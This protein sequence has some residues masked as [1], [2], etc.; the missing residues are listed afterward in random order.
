MSSLGCKL[1]LAMDIPEL[2]VIWVETHRFGNSTLG[3]ES[4]S[5]GSSPHFVTRFCLS[6]I[7]WAVFN[8]VFQR[9]H[10][11]MLRL[12]PRPS[13]WEWMFQTYVLR[14]N[15]AVV[16]HNLVKRYGPVMH[17]RAWSQDLIILSSVAAVEEFYKLHDMEFGARPSSMGRP[18]LSNALSSL[19]FPPLAT[20]WKHIH[21]VLDMTTS[22]P[23]EDMSSRG[24]EWALEAIHR[25]PEV[26]QHLCEELER[27]LEPHKPVQE[28]AIAKLP[29]LQAVVKELFRLHTPCAVS[30]PHLQSSDEYCRLLGFEVPPRT[31]VLVNMYSVQRDPVMWV[32]PDDFDPVRFVARPE[33]DLLGQ[34]F[35]LL[36]FGA[37]RRQCPGTKLAIQHVQ[38]GLARYYFQ[39]LVD[40]TSEKTS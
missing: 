27:N 7:M 17:I 21:L 3:P 31:Q 22:Q 25:H 26:V 16:L 33:V 8:L 1:S 18:T 40:K 11:R 2:S 6:A 36:P 13:A 30:F 15:P 37:G 4:I 12:P 39:R 23:F 19:C 35:H 28:S 10:L 14:R 29:Y 24:F 38:L 34:Q 20:Y 32:N 9:L 5:Q